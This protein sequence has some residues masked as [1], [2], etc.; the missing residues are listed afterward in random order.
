[1]IKPVK[2]NSY[3]LVWF[4][5]LNRQKYTSP[6][7]TLIIVLYLYRLSFTYIVILS[8]EFEPEM[9]IAAKTL[10]SCLELLISTPEEFSI[11]EVEANVP[12]STSQGLPTTV[13]EESSDS[14]NE[15][16]KLRETGIIDPAAHSVTVTL[17][18]GNTGV[19]NIIYYCC[20]EQWRPELQKILYGE[21]IIYLNNNNQFEQLPWINRFSRHTLKHSSTVLSVY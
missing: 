20:L 21:H 18:P 16:D 3:S 14:D 5:G 7:P 6:P 19:S 15:D 11:P 10:Q 2:H 9:I 8:L 12:S 4:L 1:M 13:Q 17:K